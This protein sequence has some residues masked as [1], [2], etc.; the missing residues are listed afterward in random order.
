MAESKATYFPKILSRNTSFYLLGWTPSTVDAHD[1]LY[2]IIASPGA[3]GQGQFNLGS[4]SNARFDDL[5]AK[6][7]SETDEAKRNAMISE[8]MKI[9]QDDIG[10]I[11]L[12]QQALA[13]GVKKNVSLVQLPTNDNLVKWVV[14]K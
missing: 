14:V 13:W 5:T 10:H 8:A 4:Y 3:G 9:H 2:S 1:T 6:I 7:Q 12:H 11:P